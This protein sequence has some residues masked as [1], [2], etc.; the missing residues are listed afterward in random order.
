MKGPADPQGHGFQKMIKLSKTKTK[1]KTEMEQTK[2]VEQ[3]LIAQSDSFKFYTILQK[4]GC[5]NICSKLH[6]L[7]PVV[8]K[9]SSQSSAEINDKS[10]IKKK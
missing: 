5:C 4:L 1:T 10:L 8:M 3:V 6:L 7:H 9:V 2:E